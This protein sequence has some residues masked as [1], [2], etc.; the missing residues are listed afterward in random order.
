MKIDLKSC[1]I[2]DEGWS[3]INEALPGRLVDLK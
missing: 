1:G 2:G 3:Y